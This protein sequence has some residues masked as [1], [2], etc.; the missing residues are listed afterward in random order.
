MRWE[1]QATHTVPQS[2]RTLIIDTLRQAVVCRPAAAVVCSGENL[3]TKTDRQIDRNR[4]TAREDG[5][6]VEVP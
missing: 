1:I 3:C 6:N 5:R 4:T 2:G